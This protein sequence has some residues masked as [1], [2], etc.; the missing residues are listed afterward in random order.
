M[1]YDFEIQYRKGP[2]NN[3]VDALSYLKEHFFNMSNIRADIWTKIWQ[4]QAK[5]E[6]LGRLRAAIEQNPSSIPHYSVK[7]NM[8]YKHDMVVISKGSKLISDIL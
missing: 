1:Y 5:D 3:A 7:S 6:D 2:K 4:E 8:V